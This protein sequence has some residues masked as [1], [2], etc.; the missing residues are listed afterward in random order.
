MSSVRACQVHDGV[1][2]GFKVRLGRGVSYVFEAGLPTV[3]IGFLYQYMFWQQ[4]VRQEGISP[5]SLQPQ[6]PS[7]YVGLSAQL[8]LLPPHHYSAAPAVMV[9]RD[10]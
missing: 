1:H 8:L 6:S 9:E 5:L 2:K 10:S 3:L 7:L 4:Y